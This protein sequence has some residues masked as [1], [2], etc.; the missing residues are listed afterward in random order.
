M[1]NKMYYSVL[2]LVELKSDGH[3]VLHRQQTLKSI[4]FKSPLQQ[5]IFFQKILAFLIRFLCLSKK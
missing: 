4:H 5:G 1:Y 2:I 3:S